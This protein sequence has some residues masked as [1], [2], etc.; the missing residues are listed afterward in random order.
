MPVIVNQG[1]AN[2]CRFV[3]W[4]DDEWPAKFQ[5]VACTLWDVVAK[6]KKKADDA[7]ADFLGAIALRNDLFEEKEALVREKEEW[8]K[9]RALLIRDKEEYQRESIQRAR[10]ARASCTTLQQRIAGEVQDK[11]MLFGVLLCML[12]L[13]V[14]MCCGFML[15]QK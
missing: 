7:Q 2:M 4:I 9:E 14:S 12:S 6:Y 3:K 11:K 5:E 1:R 8:S 10:F 15:K 13:I